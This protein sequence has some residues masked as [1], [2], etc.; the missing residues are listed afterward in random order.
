MSVSQRKTKRLD[1]E[2]RETIAVLY[3]QQGFSQEE[4]A[5]KLGVSQATVSRELKRGARLGEYSAKRA[6]GT[7]EK[8]MTK[9][10]GKKLK[11]SG[12]MR[13]KVLS[14]LEKRFSPQ[15]IATAIYKEDGVKLSRV[16]IYGFIK[17]EDRAGHLVKFLRRGGGRGRRR[18]GTNRLKIPNRTD[19]SERPD[20]VNRRSR[21][22]DWECD[23]I[24]GSK[25]SFSQSCRTEKPVWHPSQAVLQKVG[26]RCAGNYPSTA[27]LSGSYFDLWQRLRVCEARGSEWSI[28]LFIFLLQALRKLGKGRGR[29]FQWSGARFLPEARCFHWHFSSHSG[30]SV[31]FN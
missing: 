7:S 19:I 20:S 2:A 9:R 31:W 1:T 4:I 21:Y 5:E 24:E 16:A 29:T 12:S 8:A 27:R 28:R 6:Q 25:H 11:I 17:R 26:S 10:K 30:L 22:G 18:R 14:L 15:Q 13:H 3:N 23:L